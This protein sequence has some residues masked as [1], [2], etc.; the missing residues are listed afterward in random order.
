VKNKKEVYYYD[1]EC[2]S[3]VLRLEI[4]EDKISLDVF[5]SIYR[6]RIIGL[7]DKLRYCWQVLRWGEPFGDDMILDNQ[8]LIKLSEDLNRL[9]D[10]IQSR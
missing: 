1:C 9:K 4:E 6:Q 5:L 10:R 7:K 8:E 2:R 3:E